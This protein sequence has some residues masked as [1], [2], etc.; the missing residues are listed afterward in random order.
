MGKIWKRGIVIM[1][2]KMVFL[3]VAVLGVACL[4]CATPRES[5]KPITKI[6]KKKGGR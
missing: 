4:G 6:S 5:I 1:K 3:L 2:N